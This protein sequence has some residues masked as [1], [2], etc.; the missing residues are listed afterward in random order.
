MK[1]AIP[2][3][4]TAAFCH[5]VVTAPFPKVLFMET[6]FHSFTFVLLAEMGDKTQLLAILLAAQFRRFWPVAGGI[7]LATLLNHAVTAW[8]GVEISGFL[9]PDWLSRITGGLFIGI[10]LWVLVPDSTPELKEQA[11]AKGAF[12]T[13]LVAF[14]LAEIGDKTQLATLTLAAQ[15]HD[16]VLVTLGTTLGMLGATIPAMLLGKKI[17]T[18]IPLKQVHRIA[19]I[20]FILC[21]VWMLLR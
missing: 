15:Y 4:G 20:V 5:D 7:L 19:S 18:R 8:L 11:N 17:L 12:F 1:T 10:G 2:G 21:G 14:F 13:S 16:V 9:S 3:N 6:I